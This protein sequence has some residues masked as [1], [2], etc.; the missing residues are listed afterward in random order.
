M[1]TRTGH[2]RTRTKPTKTRT[3]TRTSLTVTYCK[4][5][6]NLQS[7]SSKSNEHKVKVHNIWLYKKLSWCLQP[8]RL[9]FPTRF[10][11]KSKNRV[12]QSFFKTE[13]PVFWLPVNPVFRFWIL[14][15]KCLI[16]NYATILTQTSCKVHDSMFLFVYIYH[17]RPV[18]QGPHSTGSSSSN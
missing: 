14:T 9:G 8:A 3:R 16:S 18:L 2:A 17:W 10:L 1:L 12:T 7:L 15:Y 13:K 11:P 6:L 4:L 5:Q